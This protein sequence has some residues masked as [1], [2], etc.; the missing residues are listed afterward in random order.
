MWP[1]LD[2]HSHGYQYMLVLPII[3]RLNVP[4]SLSLREASG[5]FESLSNETELELETTCCPGDPSDL[6]SSSTIFFQII[7]VSQLQIHTP[8]KLTYI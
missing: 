8:N 1:S 5:V 2:N 3:Y 4:D 6:S 7:T